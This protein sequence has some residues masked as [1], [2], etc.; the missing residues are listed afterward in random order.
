M[1]DMD[2]SGERRVWRFGAVISGSPNGD[3]RVVADG[4][5]LIADDGWDRD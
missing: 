5:G 4:N 1:P 3:R 2:V